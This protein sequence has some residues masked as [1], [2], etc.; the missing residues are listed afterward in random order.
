MTIKEFMTYYTRTQFDSFDKCHDAIIKNDRIYDRV[1]RI[2]DFVHDA[3]YLYGL[4]TLIALVFGVGFEKI[5]PETVQDVYIAEIINT[6][7]ILT[8]LVSLVLM[9][10]HILIFTCPLWMFWEPPT[11]LTVEEDDTIK[12]RYKL[13]FCKKIRTKL[14]ENFDINKIEQLAK[15]T[16]H[17]DDL[18]IDFY[19]KRD[20]IC[21][22]LHKLEKEMKE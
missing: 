7:I 12:A 21:A 10:S 22:I 8:I 1:D 6:V 2:K 9:L 15:D 19:D 11:W 5:Q 16:Y 3:P 18:N 4:I 14:S 13:E 17:I 20:R